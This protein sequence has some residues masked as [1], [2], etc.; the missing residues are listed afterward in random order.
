M[1]ESR[2]IEQARKAIDLI[3][4]KTITRV[5]SHIHPDLDSLCSLFFLSLLSKNLKF[6]FVSVPFFGIE[7]LP[8]DSVAIDILGG[9]IDHHDMQGKHFSTCK[10]IYHIL[11][12]QGNPEIERYRKLIDYCHRADMGS[13]I[14]GEKD[15]GSFIHTMYGLRDTLDPLELYSVF[16]YLANLVPNNDSIL[17]SLADITAAAL[18]TKYSDILASENIEKPALI[19]K[20]VR[21]VEIGKPGRGRSYFIA[22]NRSNHNIINIIFD[23]YKNVVAIVYASTNGRSGIVIR[24]DSPVSFNLEAIKDHIVN[25]LKEGNWYL[26]PNKKMLLCG[27]QKMDI[28]SKIDPE[29]LVDLLYQNRI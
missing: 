18:N 4:N 26:H 25:V 1:A 19:R 14:E 7:K 12:T 9:A 13:L 23:Y 28:E 8:Q 24:K 2:N 16:E 6:E 22:V 27:S 29:V 3:Q 11:M 10:I 20:F 21:F 5:Y 15:Q 17:T